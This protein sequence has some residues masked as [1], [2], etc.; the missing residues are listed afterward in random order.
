MIAFYRLFK[1]IYKNLL[2]K[3]NQKNLDISELWFNFAVINM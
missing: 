2:Q 3:N 1:I